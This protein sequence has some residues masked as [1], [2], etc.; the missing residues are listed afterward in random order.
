MFVIVFNNDGIFNKTEYN[1]CVVIILV[2]LKSKGEMNN[3]TTENTITLRKGESFTG[4]IIAMWYSADKTSQNSLTSNIT[5][6]E[7][8]ITVSVEMHG[9]FVR[10][11]RTERSSHFYIAEGTDTYLSTDY[12]I[13]TNALTYFVKSVPGNW[14]NLGVSI[15][16]FPLKTPLP[17]CQN[18][19]V[20][21]SR[22]GLSFGQVG[23]WP[24]WRA[25]HIVCVLFSLPEGITQSISGVVG[26]L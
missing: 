13:I 17:L 7:S 12:K 18:C 8:P 26:W 23:W 21:S 1:S 5:K 2:T 9:L 14:W 4:F 16:T 11:N 6:A 22:R 20:L 15:K 10:S 25:C 19:G 3:N 24:R